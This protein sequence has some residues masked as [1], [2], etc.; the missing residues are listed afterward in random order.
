MQAVRVIS[1]SCLVIQGAAL[2]TREMKHLLDN[3]L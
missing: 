3:G 1:E 2:Q